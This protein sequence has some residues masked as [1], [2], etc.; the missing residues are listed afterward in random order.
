MDNDF[1]PG[2]RLDSWKEIACVVGFDK[3]TCRRWEKSLGLP[4]HRMEGL[5]R[6]RVFADR[7]EIEAWLLRK[8]RNGQIHGNESVLGLDSAQKRRFVPF[9]RAV[10]VFVPFG[11][12]I[13]AAGALMLTK[14]PVLR[15]WMDR[16]PVSIDYSYRTLSVLNKNKETIWKK[17]FE[18]ELSG[19]SRFF[20]FLDANGDGEKE[21]LWSY[22]PSTPGEAFSELVCYSSVGREL[23][24]Y[25]L[26]R[27]LKT[28]AGPRSSQYLIK[29]I[30]NLPPSGAEGL[31][32]AVIS[33][34]VPWDPC[35]LTILDSRGQKLGEYVNR[36]HFAG[37][38]FI[39][40]DFDGDGRREVLVAGVNNVYGRACLVVFDADRI[41]GV[42]PQAG[43]I[44]KEVFVD[45]KV[46]KTK[47]YLLFPKSIVNLKSEPRNI[48]SNVELHPRERQIDVT[49]MER[50]DGPSIKY[51]F[52]YDF[53][54][55]SAT[56]ED[57]YRRALKDL[58]VRGV[59][60]EYGDKEIE[61]LADQ[62]DSWNGQRW[63]R[64]ARAHSSAGSRPAGPKLRTGTP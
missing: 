51:L 57:D 50:I 21:L 5:P 56:P 3:R 11:M 35:L 59:V 44:A 36:G 41:E 6:S 49:V 58:Q 31:R 54:P 53:R 16:E 27:D 43:T 30:H 61:A 37:G 60:G 15:F 40:Q 8:R 19:N 63:V 13:M 12:L 4:V 48:V 24:R 9:S 25:P 18:T 33:T 55:I 46:G 39:C 23:W 34:N 28:P 17:R 26:V 45:E 2:E 32:I 62:I 47:L 29:A 52:D 1:A 10:Y 14:Y 7:R 22:S 20:L 42:S 64:L 38:I